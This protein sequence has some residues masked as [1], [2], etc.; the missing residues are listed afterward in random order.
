M[1]QAPRDQNRIPTLL[2][3][4]NADGVTPVVVYADPVTHRLLVDLGGGGSGTVTSVSVVTANG[5]AGTVANATTTPAITLETTVTGILQGNG[6]AISA[7]VVGTGLNF[8]GGTLS[9]AAAGLTVGSSPITGG[10]NTRILYDNAGVLGEYTITGTG[11]VVAMQ[12]SPTL[13]TPNIGV[14]TGTSLDVSGVLESG[15][16]G[17]TGGQLTLL[18]STSGSVVLRVAAAA[19][20]G[21]IFQLPADN[22]TNTYVLQTNGS[23]VTSWVPQSGGGGT[24]GAPTDSIQYNDAGSFGGSATLLFNGTDTI[25]FGTEGSNATLQ[26]VDATTT[27][28]EGGGIII[29]TGAGDGTEDA[30]RFEVQIGNAGATG[31]G[32]D[33]T[34]VAGVGG[35]TSGDGGNVSLIAGSAATEGTGGSILFGAGGGTGTNQ[36]GGNVELTAGAGTG[37]GQDGQFVFVPLGGAGNANGILNFDN[38]AST[39]KTF[40]F[41]NASGTIALSDNVATITVANEATDTTC[42]PLFVTAAT[43]NLGPKSNAGLT[44]NS[45]TALLT[46]TLL[47]GTT[48]VTSATI[49]A[50]SNDS[51]SLGASGTA[52]SDLFLASGALIDFAAGNA[53]I[54]HSSGILTV[55]TGELRVTTAGT[56][57]ASVP[58]L[59]STSTLTNKTLSHTVE[60]TSDD[61]YTGE[62]M[63]GLNAGDT[64]AQWDAV[65]LDSSSGRWEFT[66]ADAAAT[67]GGV[68]VGLAASSGTDGNPLTV[69]LR[70]VIRND[71]WNW[72]TVGAPLYL[73]TTAGAITQ[74]AP[75]GT[76]DVIRIVGYVL[77]DDCI[78]F[79]P[80]SDWITH[81]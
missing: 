12:T 73:S 22:G 31:N 13:V 5:F 28:T 20:T 74:T 15:A 17:G 76:D 66:D 55:S 1:A 62:N 2:G 33:I 10:A 75:S 32:G 52:F 30:G 40:T 81:V 53:V 29:L 61:T 63:T 6:T 11:T 26:G 23:G 27:D 60:P 45:N 43:G 68:L 56:N 70:G 3:T 72:T 39:D 8:S 16:N 77:S 24:P 48:S 69:V 18:G 67:A 49:R 50:S 54:T 7:I 80:S 37:S 42:F 58:T 21:T 36:P 59:G 25:T 79:N 65:Y 9:A 4:S 64:I 35:S 71:G 38:I 51:G 44:F 47:A 46:A 14:A 41:P 57:S 19:G 78:Y 34:L